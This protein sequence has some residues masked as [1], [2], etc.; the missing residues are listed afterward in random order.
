M[1]VGVEGQGHGSAGS[2][3]R[4]VAVLI[5]AVI[6]LSVIGLAMVIDSYPWRIALFMVSF[7]LSGFVLLAPGVGVETRS[8]LGSSAA[9]RER[10]WTD[11]FFLVGSLVAGLLSLYA[12][13][14]PR[15][16][17]AGGTFYTFSMVFLA[18]WYFRR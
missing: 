15:S 6:F 14:G 12:F 9:E 17:A 16:V 3:L 13:F 2:P 8:G 10:D 1:A 18:V 7:P 4:S 11:R 5:A